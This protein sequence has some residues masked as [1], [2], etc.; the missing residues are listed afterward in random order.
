MKT[1]K[2]G[3]KIHKKKNTKSKQQDF[4]YQ[5]NINRRMKGKKEKIRKKKRIRRAWEHR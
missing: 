1:K 5:E 2:E 4:I 3:K